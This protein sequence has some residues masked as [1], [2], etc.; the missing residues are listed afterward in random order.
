MRLNQRCEERSSGDVRENEGERGEGSGLCSREPGI[1]P[2]AGSAIG[3]I[4][5]AFSPRYLS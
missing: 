1:V 2:Q 4:E 3:V 5:F